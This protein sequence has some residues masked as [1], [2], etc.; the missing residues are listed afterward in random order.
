M[1]LNLPGKPYLA[2]SSTIRNLIFG[3]ICY[4]VLAGIR[5]NLISGFIRYLE[6]GKKVYPVHLYL[7][8]MMMIK[9]QNVSLHISFLI[10]YG[11]LIGCIILLP[12]EVVLWLVTR[13]LFPA[14]VVLCSQSEYQRIREMLSFWWTSLS[15]H[16]PRATTWECCCRRPG[17]S[18]WRAAYECA[19]TW[20]SCSPA[21]TG[22]SARCRDARST[23]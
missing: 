19:R 5:W 3:R 14:E 20:A 1:T 23:R 7:R 11:S 10:F 17:S 22:T 15:R 9:H 21:C 4:P 16:V 18:R 8:M 13:I 6:S 2:L 12:Q